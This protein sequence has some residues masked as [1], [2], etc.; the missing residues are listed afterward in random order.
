MTA[1]LARST[2]L[3]AVLC[4]S[5]VAEA[6]PAPAVDDAT[7]DNLVI[8]SS[9]NVVLQW[10]ALALQAIRDT[11]PAPPVAARAL[12][13]A[14]T[15][16]FDA[17]TAYDGHAVG[18]RLGSS[19]RRPRAERTLA[20]KREAVSYAAYRTLADLFPAQLP[21]FDALLRT[22][23]HDP[24]NGSADATTAA[25]VGNTV[26]GALL[27]YRHHDGSNQ[28]GDLAPGPYADYTGY[29]PV[30]SPDV[31]T[32]PSR[33]QP[34]RLPSG[35]VQ[36]FS[37]PQWGRIVPF[38]IGSGSRFRSPPPPAFTG[39]E[40]L[41]EVDELVAL[42]ANLDD[43]TKAIAEYWSDG[44]R[45]ELPPGHWN[46]IA[47]WVSKRDRNSLDKDVKL[48]FALTNAQLDAGI[49]AWDTKRAY[50]NERPI[51][52]V[53][54]LKRGTISAWSGPYRGT[55]EIPGETWQPYFRPDVITPPFSDHVSG[56]S[57]FSA[58]S[59]TVLAAFTLS[60]SFGASATV[61]TGTSLVEPGATPSRDVTLTWPT[62]SAAADEAGFSR[63][64]A[65][66]HYRSAD[67]AARQMG[68]KVGVVVV[69]KA[70]AYILGLARG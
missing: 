26:A 12:A 30:N 39:A 13:I 70:L 61:R 43:R 48:F 23:G 17:W 69:A 6:R 45:S 63:R 10:N 8:T 21:A 5:V 16:M 51:T 1:R 32:D 4:M 27:S 50:D 65:G 34:L 19:L 24:A 2:I 35:A 64:L 9:D 53:R 66:I 42:S 67:L 15:A 11:S 62:F 52:G 3:L 7:L 68:R 37:V 38:A 47:Q 41:A 18:T 57:A 29:Q 60:D 49:A 36:R 22:L 55:Q 54:Y 25:G 56:H 20:N 31:L 58:A 28:L 33:W 44:P 14:H 59:A 46:L 40:H